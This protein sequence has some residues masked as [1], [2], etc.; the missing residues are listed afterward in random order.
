MGWNYKYYL[1]NVLPECMKNTAIREKIV[2]LLALTNPITINK[3]HYFILLASLGVFTDLINLYLNQR[4]I[5][6]VCRELDY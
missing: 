6:C 4:K 3:L 5:L 1:T 2:L